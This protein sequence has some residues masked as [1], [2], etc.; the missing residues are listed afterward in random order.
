[1]IQIRLSQLIGQC[2]SYNRP[3]P[4]GC[5]SILTMWTWASLGVWWQKI[6]NWHCQSKACYAW[7]L[8]SSSSCTIIVWHSFLCTN[9]LSPL[10]DWERE[11]VQFWH[12]RKILHFIRRMGTPSLLSHDSLS[13]LWNL[14]QLD[15]RAWGEG[16]GMRVMDAKLLFLLQQA[17]IETWFNFF[18]N[19]LMFFSKWLVFSPSSGPGHVPITWTHTP[20]SPLGMWYCTVWSYWVQAII[21]ECVLCLCAFKMHLFAYGWCLHTFFF[22]D[23][24]EDHATLLSHFGLSNYNVQ[25]SSFPPSLGFRIWAR[26]T[27]HEIIEDQGSVSGTATKRS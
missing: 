24:G 5:T 6:Q 2:L 18:S 13:C 16:H 22:Q 19:I 17:C 1:M 26:T 12:T 25:G 23:K 27:I 21:N 4:P 10:Q 20:A 9:L 7:P 14:V 8:S 15:Q 11:V 3:G